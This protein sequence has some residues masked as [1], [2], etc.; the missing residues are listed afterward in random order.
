M[1][2]IFTFV[3]FCKAKVIFYV[4]RFFLQICINLSLEP[5]SVC[6]MQIKL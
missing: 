6:D 4:K 2:T 1:E 3:I 5:V